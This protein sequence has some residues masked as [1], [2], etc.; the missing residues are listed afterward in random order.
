MLLQN[1]LAALRLIF[2]ELNLQGAISLEAGANAQQG[3]WARLSS[4][5]AIPSRRGGQAKFRAL[6]RSEFFNSI[7]EKL[8]RSRADRRLAPHHRDA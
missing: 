3:P 5:A 2:V 4:Y 8:K 6:A 1:S 7:G